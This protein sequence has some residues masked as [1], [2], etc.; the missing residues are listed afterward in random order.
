MTRSATPKL[1]AYLALVA[2]LLVAAFATRRAEMVALAAPFAVLLVV[3][4]SRTG[5]VPVLEVSVLWPCNR[6][7]QGEEL[8]LR[9]T[10]AT[11]SYLKLLDV[12]VS[13]PEG[14]EPPLR[15]LTLADLE[16][17]KRHT[18]DLPVRVSRW[19]VFTWARCALR[20]RS[21]AGLLRDDGLFEASYALRVYPSSETLRAMI[22]PLETQPSAGDL[23]A[24]AVGSG[25]EFAETRPMQPGDDLRHVNWRATARRGETWVNARRPERNADVILFLDTFT[26]LT[27]AREGTFDLTVR[28][29]STLAAHYL[30]RR[31]RVGVI[32]FG[33][34]LRWLTPGSGQHQLYQ[35][36]ES[37]ITSE[38]SFS[39]AWKDVSVIPPKTL[40]AQ[41]LVIG[42]TPLVDE[43][44]VT[45]LFD[46]LRRRFDLA[47]FALSL[48]AFLPPPSNETARLARRI[49]QLDR[50]VLLNRYRELGGAAVSWSGDTP[51]EAALF[52]VTRF[53]RH[54]HIIN[55]S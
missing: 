1:H 16:A 12:A 17:G 7:V 42:I 24:R 35:I 13:L 30:H 20:V 9:L 6:V 22:L 29:A 39:Y 21:P 14:L 50:E 52:E 46:L 11:D 18:V 51:L 54:A 10:L 37:L 47:I 5:A 15:Q 26:D 23:V 19:G 4:L 40:P 55:A 3:G 48:E 32:G 31:D 8:C 28:A 43:R 2:V 36:V 38:L 49:W 53:R 25:I 27:S 34:T 41:A 33:G 45:A 44:V